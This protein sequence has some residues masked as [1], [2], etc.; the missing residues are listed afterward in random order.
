MGWTTVQPTPPDMSKRGAGVCLEFKQSNKHEEYLYWFHGF[1]S[2]RGYCSAELPVL[3]KTSDGKGGK[4]FYLRFRSWSFSSLEWMHTAFYGTGTKIVPSIELLRMYLTPL[5]LAV[6]I[7]DD[8]SSSNAG[9]I[10]HTNA[11]SKQ[12]VQLLSNVLNELYDLNAK[13]SKRAV[14]YVVYIPKA[15]LPK[16]AAII[17]PHMVPSMYAHKLKN[18]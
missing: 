16:L 10:L 6:W 15:S 9:L 8:G 2:S 3:K 14:Y 18:L 5:A 11:F 4:H 17:K 1:M 12:D 7:S 13:V